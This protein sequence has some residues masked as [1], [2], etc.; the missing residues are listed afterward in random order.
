[1]SQNMFLALKACNKNW[2]MQVFGLGMV[3]KNKEDIPLNWFC[4]SEIV[5]VE[6]RAKAGWKQ[7]KQKPEMLRETEIL[8]L[9]FLFIFIEKKHYQVYTCI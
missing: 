6:L 3:G 2:S 4:L 8:N 7:G 5:G 1:M 9:T